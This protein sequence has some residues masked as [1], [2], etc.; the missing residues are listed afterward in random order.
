MEL[1]KLVKRFEDG[2]KLTKDGIIE[3]YKML[4]NYVIEVPIKVTGMLMEFKDFSKSPYE[5]IV[6]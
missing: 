1:S 2:Y 4:M 6:R 3:V 5:L